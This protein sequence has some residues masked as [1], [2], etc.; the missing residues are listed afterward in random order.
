M[1]RADRR[2][3]A[4]ATG[5]TA[6]ADV[7][8]TVRCILES[9]ALKHA[10]DGR[11]AR[12]ASPASTPRELHIVGGGARN[13]L[14]CQWTAEAAGLPVLAGPGGGDAARQPARPGDGARRDRVARRGAGGRARLVRADGL[15][16]ARLP[17]RGP[18]RASGSPSSRRPPSGG[19]RVSETL[20]ALHGI[21]APG[22]RWDDAAASA[23]RRPRRA[24]LPL[25]PARRRP[26]AR[27]HRRRQHVGEG[28]G[29]RPRR[30]RGPRALGEGLGH[31]SRDD[32]RRRLR[33]AAAR[34]AAAAAR[35]RG[36]GRRGDGRLPA[37]LR[38]CAP[39]SRGRRSRRCCT[40][41]SR[42]RT[43]T[44]RIPTR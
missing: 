14:L 38:A 21:P 3:T 9:L 39:I 8:E 34:R 18:R 13:E 40:P 36:D 32:H 37:A 24:R 11:R 44:T 43:S 29:R 20:G 26:R 25:E 5:Q 10:R 4:R 23:S 15:R 6:P 1:P 31:R 17:T 28:D 16:A 22:D 27:E 35:A 12:G 7:G 33:R 42:R 2:R 19:D 30:P 41:S